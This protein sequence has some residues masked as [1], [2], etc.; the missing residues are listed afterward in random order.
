MN[1]V[2]VEITGH[3]ADTPELRLTGDG[4]PVTNFT[5]IAN[6][7]RY[8]EDRREWVDTHTTAIRV[9]AWRKLAENTVGT[10][11]VGTKVT[12]TGARLTAD[13]Y[14]GRDGAARASLELTADTVTVDLSTQTAVV[15]RAPRPAVA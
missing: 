12:V 7:R 2:R 3:L 9:T 8:D 4:T 10:I 13:A 14:T 11:G 1:A 15:S 6:A 5:V